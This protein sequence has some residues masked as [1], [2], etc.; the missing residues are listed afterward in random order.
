MNQN[1]TAFTK[2]LTDIQW[3]GF[4]LGGPACR[5][6]KEGRK[7]FFFISEQAEPETISGAF[8]YFRVPTAT[9][10]AGRFLADHRQ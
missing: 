9:G 8:N 4:T 6:N 5:P 10:T 7:L 3:V 2:P 1:K